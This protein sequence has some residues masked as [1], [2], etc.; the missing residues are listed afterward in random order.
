MLL[1]RGSK[2][3]SEGDYLIY[4]KPILDK[5]NEQIGMLHLRSN[6]KKEL[7]KLLL[8]YAGILAVVLTFSILLTALLSSRLQRVISEPIL[9]LAQTAKIVAEQK[10]YS[11]RA[12]KLEADEIGQFTDAF[13]Q[14]L[15]QIQG[16]DTALRLSQQKFETLVNSIEGVV[17]E[18]D[19]ETFRFVFV[20]KQAERLLGYPL[21]QWL[22]TESFWEDHLHPEDRERAVQTSRIAMIEKRFC[23]QEYRMLALNGSI[24]WIRSYSTVVLEDSEPVLLRGVLLDFTREKKAAEELAALHAELL[25]TSH[26][27]GMAEV[28]TGVLHNVGNVLNSVNVSTTLVRERIR[29]SEVTTLG[30]VA[31][32]LGAH[33]A[34]LPAFLT[35]DPKGKMVAGFIQR[36]AD[37]LSKERTETM[38]ELEL[39]AKNIEHIK[40]IVALQQSY[41]RVCGVVESLPVTELVEDALQINSTAFRRHGVEVVRQFEP[42]PLVSVNRH[43]VLQI[44]VNLLSNAKYAVDQA[45][46][47][48]KRLVLSVA[49]DG[50][51]RVS[52]SVQDNGIGIAPENLT[53]I[54]SHGFTT[55]KE[56][57][58]FGL[59]SGALA[60]KE[61]GGALYAQSDGAGRGATFTLELPISEEQIKK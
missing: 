44:L 32:L 29:E 33:H 38:C 9:R 24:L 22:E 37:Q 6:Y 26:Q 56:G 12:S 40:E 27:A 49:L 41:A 53:R 36:L 50:N 34:D 21:E 31:A 8:S 57:H 10:D 7:R 20:S 30:R 4:S 42:V 51:N 55:K 39:L 14:M 54:F 16:R 28:A 1:E 25:Q 48:N 46:V 52:I 59:H 15:E 35:T 45:A 17:W 19:P 23:S 2:I 13:N 60:A 43:K 58:G 18:A 61:M 11:V 47:E 3:Y 5:E